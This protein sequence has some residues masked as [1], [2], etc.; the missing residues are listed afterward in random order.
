MTEARR[1]LPPRRHRGGWLIV[2]VPLVLLVAGTWILLGIRRQADLGNLPLQP[3]T[4]QASTPQAPTRSASASPGD[5]TPSGRPHRADAAA[6]LKGCRAKVQAGDKVLA[7]GKKGMGHWSDH[8]QA[9]TD[10]K[11]GKITVK[12]MDV[13]FDRTRKAGDE[14]EQRYRKAVK[15]HNERSGSCKEVRGASATVARQLAR[16]AKRGHA[17][18]PVMDAAKNGMGDWTRHLA[19]MRKSMKGKIHNPQKK[20]LQTWRAA[21]PH[22][23]AYNKAAAHFS[24]PNC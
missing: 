10:A 6:A 7:A 17:Q 18:E 23:K 13:I 12:E 22:I 16:C 11:A 4:T 15:T 21:P 1:A 14:D 19:V 20:W 5:P 24:A 3:S 9:Q 8:I 2:I